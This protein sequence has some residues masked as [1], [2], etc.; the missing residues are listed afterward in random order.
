MKKAFLIICIIGTLLNVLANEPEN[1]IFLKND[2]GNFQSDFSKTRFSTEID[3]LKN[4]ETEI[5]SSRKS[6]KPFIVPAVL[7]TTGTILNYSDEAKQN[8]Q[9]WMIENFAYSGNV[10]DWIRYIPGVAV[11]GLNAFG[12]KG[13]NN[14]GNCTAILIKTVVFNQVLTGTLKSAF[15][16]ERPNGGE[17]S[18]P[19][20]HTSIAFALAEFMHREYGG[21]SVWYSVGAYSCATTVGLMRV[22]K[23]AHW[24]S[25]VIAGAGI[26]MLSTELV[27]LTHRYKWGKKSLSQLDV[28]PFS[29]KKQ[30]G[31]MLV[32]TF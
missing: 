22:A 15:N 16:E 1:D 11:F 13:K 4:S 29:N 3:S 8:F 30:N 18:F 32:Y 2:Q 20:G 24:I 31:V 7:I 26:G 21:K 25:D 27:Y 12:V 17:H 9:N 10:D 14:L 28:I 23:N 19:S 5:K 6:I